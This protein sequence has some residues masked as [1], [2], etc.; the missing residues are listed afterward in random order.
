MNYYSDTDTDSEY[1]YDYDTDSQES[2]FLFVQEE[3][4]DEEDYSDMPDL[5]DPDLEDGHI[6]IFY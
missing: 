3:S 4:S 1:E 6:W 5:I 2:S